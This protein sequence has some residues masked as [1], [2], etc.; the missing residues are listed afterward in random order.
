M[1]QIQDKKTITEN[2][3]WQLVGLVTASIELDTKRT[4][5]YQ[6]WREIVNVE[7]EDRFWDWGYGES[8][9]SDLIG[10]IKSKLKFDG[11]VIKQSKKGSQKLSE[12]AEK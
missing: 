11:I 12:V 5:L 8:S 2:Q 1:K 6:A 9:N 7:A 3:F 10:D 4:M